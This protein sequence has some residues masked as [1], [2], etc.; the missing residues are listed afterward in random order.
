MA[1]AG[2]LLG[3]DGPGGTDSVF[4]EH[5]LLRFVAASAELRLIVEDFVKWLGNGRPP[6]ATYWALKSGR[7][8]A[9]EKQ[10]RI[11][12]V[13]V[14]ET[15]RWMMVKCL[16]RVAGPEA[17][18]A[19][20][21]TQLAGGVEAGIEGAIHVIRVLW[22]EH[23]M[24]ED[25][26]FLLIDAHN[27]FDEENRTAMLW[28]VWHEWPS[29]AQFTFNCYHHWATLV[30]RDTRDGSGHF[31]HSKE[32]VTQGDPLAMIAYCIGV[33]PLIREIRN[34]HSQV[35]QPWYAD[36]TGA[37]GTFQQVLEHFR[38]LHARGPDRG[39]YPE[40]TNSILVVDPGNLAQSEEHFRGLGIRVVTGYHYLGEYI[41]EREAEGSWV[42]AKIKGWT[43]SVA[44]LAGVS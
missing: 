4:L 14:G 24:E 42:E 43:E 29:G 15:W 3:G 35:T 8:I 12:P 25:W 2:R 5:W 30:V 26:V 23:Q 38:D 17:K 41:G 28:S 18:P 37:R 27:A 22:E 7:L 31:L 10:P 39:Y 44:I 19:C 13:G 40:P 21:T 16:L 32:G 33:L 36:D 34:A 20:G 1:V 6:R 9:L 11:R